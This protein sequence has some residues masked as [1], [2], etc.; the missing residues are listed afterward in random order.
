MLTGPRWY[1]NINLF[2][3]GYGFHPCLRDRLTLSGL[4]F[5]RKP[6]TFGEQ[7][8]HLLYRYLCRQGLFRTLHQSSQSDFD[9]YGMLL[10][11]SNPKVEIRSFGD[12]L[13]P[14]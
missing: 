11:H 5:L 9:A 4:T 3:I 6:S 8:S 2:P 1:R 13:E 10:Y 12:P 14:R 7:G